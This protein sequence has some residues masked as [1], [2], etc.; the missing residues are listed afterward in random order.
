MWLENRYGGWGIFLDNW[1]WPAHPHLCNEAKSIMTITKEEI[2][3]DS[4]GTSP[5]LSHLSEK[6]NK[7]IL[8]AKQKHAF[9]VFGFLQ[10]HCK[11]V[12]NLVKS[13]SKLKNINPIVH[14][15]IWIKKEH[16]HT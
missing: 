13:Y 5:F 12:L 16:I 8:M 3:V 10:K 4:S 7:D 1:D 9:H 11:F 6:M 14:S 2:D 15:W